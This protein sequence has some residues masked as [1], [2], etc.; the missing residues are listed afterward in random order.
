[1]Q[2]DKTLILYSEVNHIVAWVLSQDLRGFNLYL[3]ADSWYYLAAILFFAKSL[4]AN[5]HWS[6]QALILDIRLL[7]CNYLLFLQS[8]L[9]RWHLAALLLGRLP[10]TMIW[11]IWI[12]IANLFNL[13][14]ITPLALLILFQRRYLD[15]IEWD[16]YPQRWLSHFA[17]C[18]WVHLVKLLWAACAHLRLNL[19]WRREIKLPWLHPTAT[20]PAWLS[21]ARRRSA[22]MVLKRWVSLL[23]RE[24]QLEHASKL[25][26][27]I[28]WALLSSSS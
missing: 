2:R 23:I 10:L 3:I 12:H 25:R 21:L 15:I 19:L 28:F 13:A 4:L 11:E 18:C 6:L 20:S 27:A 8:L 24:R 26:D 7:L 9:F 14:N 22:W 17:H 1:M 16:V 5:S